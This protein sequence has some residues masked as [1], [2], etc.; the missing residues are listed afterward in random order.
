MHFGLATQRLAPLSQNT[1]AQIHDSLNILD[2]LAGMADHEIELDVHPTACINFTSRIEQLLIGNELVDD[3]AH[4]FGG[5]LRG[6]CE[7]TGTPILEFLHQGNRDSVNTQGGKRDR[8]VAT[9]ELLADPA[10]EFEH[11]GVIGG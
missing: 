7:P 6:E 3:T 10:D 4:A 11:V 5:S 9:A 2:R 8:Q 1:L